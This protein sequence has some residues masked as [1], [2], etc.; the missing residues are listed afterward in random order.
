MTA[1]H[2][3]VA[4]L[5]LFGALV[6]ISAALAAGVKEAERRHQEFVDITDADWGTE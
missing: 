2:L 3:G 6:L 4:C 1:A 5:I